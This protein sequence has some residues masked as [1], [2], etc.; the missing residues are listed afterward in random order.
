MREACGARGLLSAAHLD[1][2]AELLC[3]NARVLRAVLADGP[4]LRCVLESHA[5]P[6][7]DLVHDSGSGRALWAQWA[8]PDAGWPETVLTLPDC[9]AATRRGPVCWSY[10]SHPGAHTWELTPLWATGMS[11]APPQA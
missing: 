1:A 9:P 3:G 4:E 7:M 10:L 6:H 11:P 5:G 8:G 2:L